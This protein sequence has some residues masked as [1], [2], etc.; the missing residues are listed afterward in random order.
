MK[1]CTKHSFHVRYTC[2]MCEAVI[3]YS[4]LSDN[5]ANAFEHGYNGLNRISVETNDA[6]D[7][8]AAYRKMY[9]TD[10]VSEGAPI[11]K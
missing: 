3:T 8:G 9:N 4:L 1:Y 2:P 6:Y 7:R 11:N 10:A 5:H